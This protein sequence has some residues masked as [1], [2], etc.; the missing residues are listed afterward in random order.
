[1]ITSGVKSSAAVPQTTATGATA[2]GLRDQFL[3]LLATQ[4]QHQDPLNPISDQDF[5]AQLAQ[6]S[7]LE[8]MQT[9]NSNFTQLLQ[10]QQLSQGAN[11]IGK[12][13]VYQDPGQ[14]AG[15]GVVDSVSVQSGKLL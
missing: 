3:Q 5:A 12:Q 14:A 1:M 8:Q 11:L 6:F 2:A 9:L 10:L 4:L 7:S 13:V 15:H